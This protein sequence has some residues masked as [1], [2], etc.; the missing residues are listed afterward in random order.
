M[1]F[2]SSLEI[3]YPYDLIS[4]QDLRHIAED[5]TFAEKYPLLTHIAKNLTKLQAGGPLLPK[6][7]EFYLW[8]H[9]DLK[10]ALT[11]DEV[12]NKTLGEVMEEFGDDYH[13]NLYEEVKGKDMIL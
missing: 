9:Q 2:Y 7:I 11:E 1:S 12:Q 5:Q 6:L 4:E 10:G 3:N 13:L 8:L